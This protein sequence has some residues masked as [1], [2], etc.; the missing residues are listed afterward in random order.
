MAVQQV[1][2]GPR[3]RSRCQQCT[4]QKYPRC[5][6]S[7]V[8]MHVYMMAAL[9]QHDDIKQRPCQH[10]AAISSA[11]P[12]PQGGGG[13]SRVRL[14]PGVPQQTGGPAA[15]DPASGCCCK[16]G[17][18]ADRPAALAPQEA[19]VLVGMIPIQVRTHSVQK[20][21]PFQAGRWPP[22]LPSTPP[23]HY[24]S[25][26]VVTHTQTHRHTQRQQQQQQQQHPCG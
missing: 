25:K 14:G 26:H 11:P 21:R 22:P 4:H 18:Q 23:G 12:R 17:V 1:S 7:A 16:G 19:V 15:A 5:Y 6:H 2:R 20:A 8:I 24:H 9:A 3:P 10:P 13:I